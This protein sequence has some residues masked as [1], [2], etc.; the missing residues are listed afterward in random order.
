MKGFKLMEKYTKTESHSE[1]LFKIRKKIKQTYW[2]WHKT[3]KNMCKENGGNQV[4]S[5]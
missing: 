5:E 2:A 3:R 4:L 1:G